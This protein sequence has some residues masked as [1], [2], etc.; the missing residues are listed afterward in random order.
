GV[1]VVIEHTAVSGQ[2]GPDIALLIQQ[3][4]YLVLKGRGRR[5]AETRAPIFSGR[6]D[7]FPLAGRLI[8]CQVV[9]RV[10]LLAIDRPGD[11][12]A[13]YQEAPGGAVEDQCRIAARTDGGIAQLDPGVGAR[14][15]LRFVA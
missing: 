15:L 11:S 10:R 14:C 13:E 7:V 8:K 1:L 5:V 4:E 9:K 2:V 6:I 12:A 3:V